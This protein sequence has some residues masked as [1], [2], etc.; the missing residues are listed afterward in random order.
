P[1]P[2]DA[3]RCT[4]GNRWAGPALRTRPGCV[5][6]ARSSTI[7]MPRRSHRSGAY[8]MHGG[9]P[10]RMSHDM[11]VLVVAALLLCGLWPAAGWGQDMSPDQAIRL[12]Q[13]LLRRNPR[14][15]RAYFRL[16]YSYIIMASE[17]DDVFYVIL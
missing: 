3:E 4:A 7:A 15:A 14:D 11:G 1:L 16:G 13:H 17:G 12:S 5:R 8:W 9:D 2:A 6:S 10:M